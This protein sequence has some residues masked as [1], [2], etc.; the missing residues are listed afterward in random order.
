VEQQ[1][2]PPPTE[3]TRDETES[4]GRFGRDEETR[5]SGRF[6][7]DPDPTSPELEAEQIADPES[8]GE[9]SPPEAVPVPD[10][11]QDDAGEGTPIMS[12][13]P[14]SRPQQRS[15][16]RAAPKRSAKSRA[17][18]SASGQKAPA[19]RAKAGT[20]SRGRSR[21]QASAGGRSGASAPS[22]AARSG[23][24]GIRGRAIGTAVEI[25]IAPW[26]LTFSATRRA[27]NE[28]GRRLGL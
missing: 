14:H 25:A 21:A 9:A 12:N 24:Q 19:G 5:P 28:I 15:A 13:L 7:R 22:G 10:K 18:A 16:K 4:T 3:G 26:R 2:G 11:S 20:S 23:A 6:A 8:R 1:S 17:S 27:A